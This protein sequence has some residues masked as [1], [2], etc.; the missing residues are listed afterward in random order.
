ML[1]KFMANLES[2]R[3]MFRLDEVGHKP[4]LDD[5]RLQSADSE[6]TPQAPWLRESSKLIPGEALAAYLS[7]QSVARIASRPENVKIVL[8][9]V[10]LAVT[11]VLRWLGSQDP[12]AQDANKTT[13]P[14]VIVISAVSYVFLVYASGGQIFWH[15]PIPDQQIYGQIAAA[16]LGVLGPAIHRRLQ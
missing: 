13:Q 11:I 3:G 15:R 12:A 9:I 1:R 2:I 14:W 16:A 4:N 10:F 8:A 6:Q 5:F 7:L